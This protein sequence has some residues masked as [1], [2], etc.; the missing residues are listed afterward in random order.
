MISLFIKKDIIFF[1][2]K[3]ISINIWFDIGSHNGLYT[4][5]IK[6]NFNLKK[7]YL[8]E[9]QK[10]IF[11]FIKNKY[12]NNKKIDTYNLAISNSNKVKKIYIN[13]HDL[14]SSLTKINENNFYLKL[15]AILFGG[16]IKEMITN[17]YNIKTIKLSNFIK[18]KKL[19]K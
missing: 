1:K 19:K 6:K 13:K 14:T 2:K 18:Q 4:D 11:K 3:N 9:P 5:L 12:R 8:F 17:N 16:N 7:G 15:K 10:N